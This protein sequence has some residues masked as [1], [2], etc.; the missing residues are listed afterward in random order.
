MEVVRNASHICVIQR[1]IKQHRRFYLYYEMAARDYD[2]N[3]SYLME[4]FL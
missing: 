4:A 3:D 1:K 2:M